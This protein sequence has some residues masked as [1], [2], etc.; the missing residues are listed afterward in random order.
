MSFILCVSPFSGLP[1]NVL[2]FAGTSC[3]VWPK[4]PVLDVWPHQCKQRGIIASLDLLLMQLKL[5]LV[6]TGLWVL[7]F[8]ELTVS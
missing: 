4:A 6:F 1:L 7:A 8:V 2:W 5:Q 3:S